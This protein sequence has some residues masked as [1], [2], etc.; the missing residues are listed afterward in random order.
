M[1]PP[2]RQKLHG[3]NPCLAEAFR[4]LGAA[5]SIASGVV[6]SVLSTGPSVKAV[7]ACAYHAFIPRL[8]CLILRLSLQRLQS[9]YASIICAF[10]IISSP[11]HIHLI[12]MVPQLCGKMWLRFHIS[13]SFWPQVY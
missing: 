1:G 8:S 13:M 9:K 3:A 7:A 12:R 10:S 5:A 4:R 6:S 2:R 11:K